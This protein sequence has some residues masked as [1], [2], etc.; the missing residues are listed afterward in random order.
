M[1]ALNRRGHRRMT[2]DPTLGRM[3]PPAWHASST[4]ADQFGPATNYSRR[5][6]NGPSILRI[7]ALEYL[8]LNGSHDRLLPVPEGTP[9]DPHQTW[10][11]PAAI[12]NAADAETL[13][14]Y[15]L[16]KRRG[17]YDYQNRTQGGVDALA[18]M[19]EEQAPAPQPA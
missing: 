3:S 17:F 12:I 1:V 2:R 4:P 18:A 19:F 13:A 7:S 5:S 11:M 15:W 16:T 8:R 14:R 9:E 6:G 10:M